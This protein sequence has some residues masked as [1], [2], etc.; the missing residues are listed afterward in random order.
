MSYCHYLKLN[1]LAQITSRHSIPG[2]TNEAQR[3]GVLLSNLSNYQITWM[4]INTNAEPY[5]TQHNGSDR[6]IFVNVTW[7]DMI[8]NI[9]TIIVTLNFINFTQAKELAHLFPLLII[10]TMWIECDIPDLSQWQMAV[11]RAFPVSPLHSKLNG[12]L[13]S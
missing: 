12:W 1:Q 10:I 2:A 9:V 8:S 6:E 4:P 3:S 11:T 5:G 7:Y 13:F